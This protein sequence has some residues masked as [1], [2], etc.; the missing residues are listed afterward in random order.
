M[1][2]KVNVGFTYFARHPKYS[3]V[4]GHSKNQIHFLNA[5]K[6]INALETH[7]ISRCVDAI[8]LKESFSRLLKE[9]AAS[10]SVVL[11]THKLHKHKAMNYKV[12]TFL[13]YFFLKKTTN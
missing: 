9:P 11:Y 10:D 3:Q 2:C 7:R 4:H 5:F 12:D 8:F 6:I 1:S 13:F